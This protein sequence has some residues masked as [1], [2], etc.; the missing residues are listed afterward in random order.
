MNNKEFYKDIMSNVQPS[1]K[2]VER[3]FDMTLDKKANKG[4]TFK[5]LASVT[6]ALAILVGGGFGI[7]S[8]SKKNE[9]QYVSSAGYSIGG[10]MT[11]EAKNELKGG[12]NA[13]GRYDWGYRIYTKDIT[14]LSK[15]EIET[16]KENLAKL[17][18]CSGDKEIL[19]KEEHDFD[20]FTLNGVI[21]DNIKINGN[22]MYAFERGATEQCLTICGIDD[23]STVKKISVSNTSKYGQLIINADDLYYKEN[24]NGEYIFDG[25]DVNTDLTCIEGHNKSISGDRYEKCRIIENPS[26]KKFSKESFNKN[27]A[28]YGI[29]LSTGKVFYFY[30]DFTDEFFNLLGENPT[31]DLTDYKDEITIKVEFKD[32]KVS[33]NII[34]VSM[35]KNGKTYCKLNSYSFN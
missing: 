13:D 3:I 18:I 32:G 7:N 28:A 27:S 6:L 24:S 4:L 17:Y 1:E 33:K 9:K 22:M 8:L 15:E 14:G 10:I 12:T 30:Y 2:S 35:G 21:K 11:V 19:E 20:E 31:Y 34:D 16:E 29:E 25:T 23:P 5:R 26:I